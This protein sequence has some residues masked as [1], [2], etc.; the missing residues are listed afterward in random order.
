MKS[1]LTEKQKRVLEAIR[2]YQA[3][4]G[5]PPTVRELA[6]MFGQSST[7]G[8]HKILLLLQQKGF[9]RKRQGGKSRSLNVVEDPLE[10]RGDSCRACSFPIL[11]KV[12]AGMPELAVEEREGEL[13][14]DSDW[15]GKEDI[16]LLRVRGHS[17][18]DAN[19]YENDL[20][21]VQMTQSC[22][23]GDIIIALLDDEATVKRFFNE[24]E[25]IRLQPENPNMQPIYVNKHDPSFRIIGKVKGLL[26]RY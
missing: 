3:E 13:Y 14:L 19:I 21:I 23:N 24:R 11:G 2:R 26:R 16:F 22:H 9:L 10:A 18:I 6:E 4:Q 7:A 17:M 25:R 20:L 12:V 15:V 5:Y 1:E 8:I